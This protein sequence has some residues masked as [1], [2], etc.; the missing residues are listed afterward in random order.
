MESVV[1]NG[2]YMCLESSSCSSNKTSMFGIIEGDI[3]FHGTRLNP[4]L[5][6]KGCV[7]SVYPGGCDYTSCKYYFFL[8]KKKKLNNFKIKI[9]FF[10]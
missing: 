4:Q 9:K 8:C 1:F 3:G 5:T 7:F 2:M 6:V 10:Y